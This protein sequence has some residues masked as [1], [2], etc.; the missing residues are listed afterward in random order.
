MTFSVGGTP[1]PVTLTSFRLYQED[2]SVLIRWSTASEPNA[3]KYIV[4]YSEDEHRFISI[5]EVKAKGDA[6]NQA[7]YQIKH[8]PLKDGWAYYRL[9]AVDRDG[10]IKI[11]PPKAILLKN[12][13]SSIRIRPNPAS[14]EVILSNNKAFIRSIQVYDMGG[15]L[16]R[17]YKINSND[18]EIHLNVQGL[19]AGVFTIRLERQDGYEGGL[20]FEKQ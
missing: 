5:G 14:S 17:S 1:L 4:A 7:S 20:V 12:G 16:V 6:F 19:P 13:R 11:Y 9:T 2:D 18:P 8:L 10:Q 3:D 15:R